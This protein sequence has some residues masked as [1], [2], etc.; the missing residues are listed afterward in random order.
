MYRK[1]NEFNDYKVFL[2]IKNS[3]LEDFFVYRILA[4][5]RIQYSLD[6]PPLD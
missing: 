6:K 3:I 5:N 2:S 1:Y 4:K